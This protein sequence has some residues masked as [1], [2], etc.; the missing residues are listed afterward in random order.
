[1]KKG[2]KALLKTSIAIAT[3][4]CI[5][6]TSIDNS[7]LA[8][9]E[10]N[11][12]EC[13]NYD[14]VVD[15]IKSMIHGQTNKEAVEN[16]MRSLSEDEACQIVDIYN[17]HVNIDDQYNTVCSLLESKDFDSMKSYIKDNITLSEFDVLL[18]IYIN[19][20]DDINNF[21]ETYKN[22]TEEDIIENKT[23]EIEQTEIVESSEII[24]E[25]EQ[26][27]ETTEIVEGTTEEI[28]EETKPEE[29]TENNEETEI[30]ESTEQNET[31]P[32][33]EETESESNQL[34]Q[35]ELTE[36]VNGTTISISGNLPEDTELVVTELED[37]KVIKNSIEEKLNGLATVTVYKSFDISLISKEEEYEPESDN[38]SVVVTIKCEDSIENNLTVFHTD[39]NN[40][41]TEISSTINTETNTVEF[42]TESFSVYTIASVTYDTEA[43]V[44]Y[45]NEYGTGY[46][47]ADT[48]TLL[49]TAAGSSTATS[50]TKYAWYGLISNVENVIIANTV[51]SQMNFMFRNFTKIKS[52]IVE[53]G[54]PGIGTYAF[55][56]CTGLK[57]VI[58]GENLNSLGGNAFS[59]CTALNHIV[60]PDSCTSFSNSTFSGCTSLTSA[61]PIS[62]NK[63]TGYEYGWTD[64][65]PNSAFRE[66]S[67]LTNIDILLSIYKIDGYAF[68]GCSALTEVILHDGVTTIGTSG[69]DGCSSLNH[70]VV[71]ASCTSINTNVFS[72]CTSLTSASPISANKGTGYEYGWTDQLPSNAFR[73]L[74]GLINID[75]IASITAIGNYAFYSCSSLTEV[76]IPDGVTTIGGSTFYGCSSLNHIVV[77]VECVNIGTGTF[78][79]CTSLTSAS[80]ISSNKGTGYEYG[81]TDKIPKNAFRELT[82]LTDVEFIDSLTDICGYAFSG[83]TDLQS[84]VLPTE[85][86][87]IESYAFTGC[88]SLTQITAQDKI[89][90]I[91]QTAFYVNSSTDTTVITDNKVVKNYNWSGD[92]RNVT[93]Q[94]LTPI[95]DLDVCIPVNNMSFNIDGEKNFSSEPIKIVNNSPCDIDIY[96]TNITG[97]SN[98]INIVS[99]QSYTDDEWNEMTEFNN[100]AFMIN[101]IDLATAYNNSTN[102]T[103]KHISLGN[104]KSSEYEIVSSDYTYTTYDTSTATTGGKA[105]ISSGK[106][107]YVGNGSANY[108]SWTVNVENTGTYCIGIK[109]AVSGTRTT[110]IAANDVNVGS[111]T[112]TGTSWSNGFTVYTTVELQ[113]GENVIKLYNDSAY[114]PDIFNIQ[115]SNECVKDNTL[116][117]K[118]GAK[119]PRSFEIDTDFAMDYNLTFLFV[120]QEE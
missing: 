89:T 92:K 62:A 111:V 3:S 25:T 73:G 69:F 79:G 95:T 4:A 75:I 45:T 119:Y 98:A 27:E 99:S 120:S 22:S 13:A 51:T 64:V 78:S 41:T 34:V 38:N 103:D 56:G 44:E 63:G 76:I 109:G 60:V 82:K 88:S 21:I 53:D 15:T 52:V 59:G 90:S 39:D 55:D 2:L 10:E 104:I 43:G 70:I 18:S 1:M 110:Y 96:I 84:V 11:Q 9:A 83:C 71:P 40:T 65:I 32:T 68:Y 102:S 17:S 94:R 77:P 29:S 66:L 113:A 93:F 33:E 24:D 54:V 7:F 61:S 114:A 112:H 30:V 117:L 19:H 118:L 47:Y 5:V 87:N 31:E 57:E 108:V 50:N 46:Y 91:I 49:V 35:T 67:G 107:G 6:F 100:I 42:T 72:G 12:V 101:N 81:W 16:L 58:L 116:E 105:N 86:L 14:T 20:A 115:L 23:E 26:S 74:S 8:R 28:V 36:A 37:D 97:G 80:P 106:V 85:L 48:N